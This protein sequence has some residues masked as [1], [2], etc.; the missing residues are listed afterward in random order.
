[1]RDLVV[2]PDKKGFRITDPSSPVIIR[3]NRGVLFYTTEPYL[4]RIKQFNLP[5]F[6]RYKVETGAF[7]EME[8]PIKY[9]YAPIPKLLLQRFPSPFDFKIEFAQNP[10]KCTIKWGQKKIIFDNAFKEK[11]LPEVFFI[12]YHEFGH[13]FF[14]GGTP[15]KESLCDQMAGNYMLARGFNP[16]QIMKAPITALSER[17]LERKTEMVESIMEA[18]EYHV[19]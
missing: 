19:Q 13:A 1:M 12:L 2:W 10:A 18:Q 11:P 6:G 14:N 8:K 3:D 17:Q 7:T 9:P 4:P 16:E 5:P 15:K